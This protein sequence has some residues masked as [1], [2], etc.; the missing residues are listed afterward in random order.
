MRNWKE[1]III[2]VILLICVPV[3]GEVF[4]YNT[5]TKEF[6]AKEE[7]VQPWGEISE[8]E[9][10]GFF[11]IEPI[12]NEDGSIEY[13]RK[14]TEIRYR[15]IGEYQWYWFEEHEFDIAQVNLGN[16][17]LWILIDKDYESGSEILILEG[18]TS[19][20]R[21]NNTTREI[22][23]IPRKMEGNYLSDLDNEGRTIRTIEMTMRLNT[24][25]TYIAND[26]NLG[27]QEFDYVL[28]VICENLKNEGYNPL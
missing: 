28:D 9:N 25:M 20:N 22:R 26:E 7:E 3:N 2:L 15:T 23:R 14:A 16:R 8:V 5:I 10:R 13:I 18:Q 1:T 11:I 17:L 21:I 6:T 27:N 12:Y 19:N 4:V 24:E